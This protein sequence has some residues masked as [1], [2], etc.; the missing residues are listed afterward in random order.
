MATFWPQGNDKKSIYLK[1]IEI[2][3]FEKVSCSIFW[4]KKI[5]TLNVSHIKLLS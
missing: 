2:L 1:T 5:I 4:E 3:N